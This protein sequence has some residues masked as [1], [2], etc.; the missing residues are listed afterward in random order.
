[1]SD[2]SSSRDAARKDAPSMD[3]LSDLTK[4]LLKVPKEELDRK[5]A[6]SRRG[7]NGDDANPRAERS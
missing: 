1:M 6:K 5:I 2:K 3:A 4:K 7:Q